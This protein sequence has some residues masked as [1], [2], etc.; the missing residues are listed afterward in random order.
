MGKFSTRTQVKRLLETTAMTPVEVASELGVSRSRVYYLAK[1]M[2]LPTNK[3]PVE[4]GPDEAMVIRW[5]YQGV[6]EEI[7][8]EHF[9]LSSKAYAA[10]RQQ[11]SLNSKPSVP[12]RLSS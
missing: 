11:I 5:L 4:G 6:T 9:G 7:I 1:R 10:L 8:R 3:L 2:G 12:G